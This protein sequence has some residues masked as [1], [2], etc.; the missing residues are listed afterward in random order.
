MGIGYTRQDTSNNIANG[1]VINADDLDAEF[2]AIESAFDSSSGHTHDGTSAEGAPIEVIGPNQEFISDGT[3]FY[4]KANNSYDLGRVGA[5]WKDIFIDGTANI[6]SLV[7]D[8]ATVNGTASV[9]SL[10]AST[11]EV[12]GGTLDSVTIGGTIAG[13]GTFTN[14]TATTG[15]TGTLVT[16]SQPNI[17]SVGTLDSVDVGGN[18]TVTG[19]VDG[20]NIS[21]DGA[22]LDSIE[23]GADVTDTVNVSDA[24]ALMESEVTNLSA[25]KAF[26]PADYITDVTAGTGLSGGGGSGAIV[27]EGIVQSAS[28]WEAGT[29]TTEGVVSP[30]KVRAAINTF[31]FTPTNVSGASQTLD[32]G[33]NN[34]FNAGTLTEDVNVIFSNVPNKARWSYSFIGDLL[35]SYD[36]ENAFYEGVAFNVRNEIEVPNGL[37][38]KDDGTKMYVVGAFGSK[39]VFQYSLTVPWD[40]STASYDGV[41]FSFANQISEELV[42]PNGLFFKDDGTKMYTLIDGSLYQYSV[43]SWN[44]GIASYDGISFS[45]ANEETSTRRFSFKTDGTKLYVSGGLGESVVYQYNLSIPWDISTTSYDGVSFSFTSQTSSKTGI[46]FKDDGAKMYLLGDNVFQYSL[47][48]PWDLST[49]SYD[50]VS[51]SLVN[52]DDGPQDLFFKDD[53]T[54]MY[55]VGNENDL[56]FQYKTASYGSITFPSSVQNSPS[57]SFEDNRVTYT[58]FTQDGGE[59]VHLIGEE[60]Q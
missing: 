24:G 7:A 22:K 26:D 40:L 21:S 16:P 46:F 5:E 45:F 25:V 1:N 54:K 43:Q 29:S 9:D 41:S 44:V 58:F 13:A 27:L 30:A 3:S 59:T 48:T 50:G 10:V 49:A 2:N 18:I 12:N 17:T 33:A 47:S 19:T 6:D 31:T 32:I 20:R 11:A 35:S 56:V 51:F 53:G 39:S 28:T 8:A 60:I 42:S 37:F 14:L 23:S 55:V 15:I 57:E 36:I 38:F 4:P 34:F 52:E